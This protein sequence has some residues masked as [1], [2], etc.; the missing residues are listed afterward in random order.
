MA[1]C[2]TIY[3]ECQNLK[4]QLNNCATALESGRNIDDKLID[5]TETIKN[6]LKGRLECLKVNLMSEPINSRKVWDKYKRKKYYF[7]E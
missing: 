7:I 2:E 6:T 5:E 3:S 4:L 1:T